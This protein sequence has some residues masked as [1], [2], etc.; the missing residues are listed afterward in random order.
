MSLAAEASST[1]YG[2]VAGANL[3]SAAPLALNSE[4]TSGVTLDGHTNISL[5][6]GATAIIAVPTIVRTGTGSID[7]AA[8][9]DFELLDH[10][11][12]G[13]VYT[14]GTIP[15]APTSGSTSLALGGGSMNSTIGISTI[16]TPAT[17][18][19][20]AGNITLTVQHDIIGFQNVLDTLATTGSTPSGLGSSPGA[21]LGQF[22]VPCC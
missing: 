11:A 3:Q 17:N 4:S 22:W 18:R 14:A 6:T 12:P 8:A 1:S 2:I 9:G 16:L 10:T 21:F 19:N 15:V 5:V 7:I 13:V 20:D